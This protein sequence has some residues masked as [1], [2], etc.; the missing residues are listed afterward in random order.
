MR[1]STI[2][3]RPARFGRLGR[4]LASSAL[5]L[6]PL[7]A[8]CS[9]LEVSN[10]GQVTTD[11]LDDPTNAQLTVASAITDFASSLHAGWRK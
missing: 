1:T 8:G 3:N 10:P 11:V 7:L 6:A 9:L 5:W 2:S 4:A